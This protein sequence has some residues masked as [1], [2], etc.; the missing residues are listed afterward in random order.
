MHPLLRQ[1]RMN[2]NDSKENCRKPLMTFQREI[3]SSLWEI[4]MLK[5][6]ISA[7]QELRDSLRMLAKKYKEF[8]KHLNLYFVDYQKAFDSIWREVLWHDERVRLP[9][10]GNCLILRIRLEM[11]TKELE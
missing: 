2:K 8:S 10:G 1:R 11:S 3:S 5:L 9:L 4:L 6:V 7:H